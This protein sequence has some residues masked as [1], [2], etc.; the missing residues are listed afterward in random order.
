MFRAATRRTVHSAA[1]DGARSAS[2][3]EIIYI[4]S[5]L[6]L[7]KKYLTIKRKHGLS[8]VPSQQVQRLC[9]AKYILIFTGHAA[10]PNC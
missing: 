2:K 4:L 8:R 7:R 5:M 10:P 1:A 9:H 6:V 3:S